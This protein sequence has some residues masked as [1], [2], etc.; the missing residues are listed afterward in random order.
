MG[1]SGFHGGGIHNKIIYIYTTLSLA[2]I[3]LLKN[4]HIIVTIL[5]NALK[6]K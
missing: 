6:I 3:G 5:Y 4:T 2:T 1:M